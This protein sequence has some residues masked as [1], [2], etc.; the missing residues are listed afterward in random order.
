MPNHQP[1]TCFEKEVL[2]NYLGEQLSESEEAS[3]QQHLDDCPSCQQQLERVAADQTMWESL[4]RHVSLSSDISTETETYTRRQTLIE[5]LAPTDDPRMLGRLGNYEICGFI[6]Q[7]STGIVLKAFEP[8]LNRYVAIKVLSPVYSSNGAARKRFE[9]EGRAVASVVHP[10]IVPIHAVDQFRG[11]PYIVMQYVPGL[12]LLQRLD[13]DGPIETEEVARVGLQVAKG[14]AA[15]HKVGIVH[16]DI[17]PANVILENTIERA[18]VTDFGL[19]RVAD[20]ASM[21]RSGMIAGTPQYMS[22]E[23]ARG[24]A[25]DAR[26]DLF[27]LG[28]LMYAACTAR[29]PFRAETIVG[30]I[31]RVCNTNPRPI[32]EVNPKIEQWMCDFI[33]R[34]IAKEP[35]KRFQTADELSSLLALELA[36]LQNPT[37]TIKPTREWRDVENKVAPMGE[38]QGAS[39]R[40][41]SA[42]DR[43]LAP[44]RSQLRIRLKPVLQTVAALGGIVLLTAAFIPGVGDKVTSLFSPSNNAPLIAQFDSDGKEDDSATVVETTTK[45]GAEII[46][47]KHES[48]WSTDALVTYDQKWEKSFDVD[49]DG[50]LK[51]DIDQANVLVRPADNDGSVTVTMMRRVEA[52]SLGKAKKIFDNYK[53]RMSVSDDGFELTCGSEEEDRPESVDRIVYRI[54]IPPKY[55]ANVKLKSGDITIGELDGDVTT[56]TGFGATRIGHTKGNLKV[57]GRGGCVDITAGCQGGA[58]VEGVNADVYAANIGESSQLRLSGG[59]VWIGE[60]EGEIYAQT[61]GGD[62]KVQNVLGKVAGFALDGDVEVRLD[63]SPAAGCR[64][65]TTGGELNM[66]ISSKVAATVRTTERGL[67]GFEESSDEIG[68]TDPLYDR[69]LNGGGQVVHAKVD[70]GEFNFAVLELEEGASFSDESLGGSGV[71]DGLGGSGG[72]SSNTRYNFLAAREKFSAVPGAGKI[73]NVALDRD[74]DMDGYS[75]YLPVSFDG[76]EDKYPVLISLGGSWNVGKTIDSVNNWGL[77]RLVRDES[78]LSNERNRLLLDSFIIV[79]PHIKKGQYSDHAETIQ[80]IIDTVADQYRGDTD[81]VYLTGLSRGGHGTWGLASKMPETFAAV[82]PVAGST[83]FVDSFEPIAETSVWIACNT[84]DGN[85]GETKAAIE[86]IED[87]SDEKFLV[88]HDPDVSKTDYLNQRFVLTA[89]RRDHH[90]AWTE[91]YTRNEFYKWLLQQTRD[92]SAPESVL[93]SGQGNEQ[94]VTGDSVLPKSPGVF[95]TLKLFLPN[96]N[97]KGKLI[98]DINRGS[99]EVEGYDG[100]EVVVDILMTPPKFRT[101][102][103]DDPEMKTLFSPTYDLDVDRENNSIKFD[104]Y[105]QDYALNLRIRVPREIDLSLDA[106]RDGYIEAKNVSGSIH[107]HSEHSDIRLLDISGSATAFSRNGNLTVSFLEV[108]DT[109]KLD[110]ES[111]NGAIDLTL[112]EGIAATTAISSGTGSFRTSFDIVSIEEQDGPESILS[113]VKKNVDE[114]QFGEINGGGVPLRIENENGSVAVR[115]TAN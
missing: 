33:D 89:P 76:N 111:Y 22:P 41:S 3:I 108:I 102:D 1:K 13:K 60:C 115:K 91:L 104:T 99:I 110:F 46:W 61:S 39:R 40:Y 14:L 9:R 25:I 20:D 113:K 88:V 36:Y 103:G 29:P 8:S 19:A 30:V 86:K 47:T 83:D 77:S 106:Y 94:E 53:P 44:R 52:A 65:G 45:N 32:R 43:R 73:T 56:N 78:D 101:F 62:I 34:L 68:M 74:G 4:K 97:E 90:D 49:S 11:L 95:K 59:N 87:L 6:G 50:T 81:R 7:G 112:P 51:L 54:A 12:S 92:G 82:V 18:M 93:D 114:Y 5:F 2:A 26:S 35:N 57:V 105:N 10:N 85:Y 75:V 70:S 66:L 15:A 64:F 55:N 79:A 27:S 63:K 17:K 80:Y 24:E 28:S 98:V 69:K 48:D 23:Q 100:K 67:E 107:A 71:P 38:R 72:L 58:D 109:A 84:G 31:H 16:R 21:T 96:P 37:Q 42:T